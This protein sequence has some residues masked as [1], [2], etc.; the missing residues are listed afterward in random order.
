MNIKLRFVLWLINHFSNST[1]TGK[2]NMGKERRKAA[3]RSSLGQFI[4]SKKY[5]VKNIRNFLIEDIPVRQYSNSNAP[6]QKLIIFFHGGGFSFYNIQSHDHVARR[7]CA[8]NNFTVISVGY[9]LAPEFTYPAAHEDAYKVINYIALNAGQFNVDAAKIILAGDSAGANIS[10]CACHHFKENNKVKIAA[11]IL[12][13]PW[14]DGKLNTASMDEYAHGYLLTKA[15][16]LWYRKTY[17]PNEKD[18][19]HPGLS[20]YHHHDFSL[21]PPAFILTAQFDPLKDDGMMYSEKLKASGIPTLYKEYPGVV[22]GFF[23]LP[24]IAPAGSRSY[25]DIQ[26]FINLYVQ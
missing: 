24:G 9:R 14:V 3:I 5:K 15:A 21:L 18:W 8:M 22:H 20:P 13:Y 6:A 2:V 26:E 19:L 25:R 11:Q 12:I 17:A 16:I 1:F 7:L 4:F 23:N 10:A